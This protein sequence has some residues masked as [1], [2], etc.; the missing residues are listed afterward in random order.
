MLSRIEA[1]PKLFLAYLAER[2]G[3]ERT[4]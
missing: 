4:K 3:M 2:Q 1:K